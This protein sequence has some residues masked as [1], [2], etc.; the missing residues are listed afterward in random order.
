MS[1]FQSSVCFYV[2]GKTHE[3][4][5]RAN[6]CDNEEIYLV[7]RLYCVSLPESILSNCESEPRQIVNDRYV[8]DSE[9]ELC[10]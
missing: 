1:D 7:D 10:E 2:I 6:E 8:A 5:T 4:D 9:M 3:T